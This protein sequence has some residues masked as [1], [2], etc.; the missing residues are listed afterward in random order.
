M[1][2]VLGNTL[3]QEGNIELVLY[4]YSILKTDI[5][6]KNSIALRL[7][8]CDFET[9]Y[10]RSCTGVGGILEISES[11][12]EK[13]E[14]MVPNYLYHENLNAVLLLEVFYSGLDMCRLSW[15][16]HV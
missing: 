10:F 1:F 16:L 12:S 14:E 11:P 2:C 6:F 8:V 3:V 7:A 5:M 15:F 9:L 13:L 4:Q